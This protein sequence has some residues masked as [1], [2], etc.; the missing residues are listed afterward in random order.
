MVGH[1]DEI[2]VEDGWALMLVR[3]TKSQLNRYYNSAVYYYREL[4]LQ[5]AEDTSPDVIIVDSTPGD[6]QK[7]QSLQASHPDRVAPSEHST[8]LASSSSSASSV[9]DQHSSRLASTSSTGADQA[10]SDVC[11]LDKIL[12]TFAEK[13]SPNAIMSIFRLCGD[14]F[15]SSVDCLLAGPTLSSILKVVDARFAE[16]PKKKVE[17]D[18]DDAWADTVAY[19]KSPQLNLNKRV[20]VVLGSQPPVDTGG[21]RR[22]LYSSVFA[23]FADN[24]HIQLFDG[25]VNH[26]R[27]VCTAEARASGLF[28]VLGIMVAHSICQDGIGFSYFSPVCYWYMVGEEKALQFASVQDVGGDVA[29]SWVSVTSYYIIKRKMSTWPFV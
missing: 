2:D 11:Y 9:A 22:Q 14:D 21:V 6:R 20:R 19:Y 28:K 15:D 17:I 10:D 18:P 23:E 1:V 12:D 5:Q 24:K 25:P 7:V 29:A 16:L 26:R 4:Q 3:S 8:D 13:H 27:L